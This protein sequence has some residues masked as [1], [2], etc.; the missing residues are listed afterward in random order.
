MGELRAVR[1]SLFMFIVWNAASSIL[2][3]HFVFSRWISKNNLCETLL[4]FW[5]KL[6]MSLQKNEDETIAVARNL[7]HVGNNSS[8][9]VTVL[10]QG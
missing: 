8:R 2:L 3:C 7:S 1:V 5:T 4:G 6:L 9:N 10:T